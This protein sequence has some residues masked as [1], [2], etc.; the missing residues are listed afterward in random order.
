MFWRELSKETRNIILY[1]WGI[2]I[3]LAI[4]LGVVVA[5]LPD[6]G[7]SRQVALAVGQVQTAA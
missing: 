1:W 6:I 5:L 7:G 3:G 2:P 4:I